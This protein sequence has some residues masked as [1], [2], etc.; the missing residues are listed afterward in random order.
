MQNAGMTTRPFKVETASQAIVAL[1]MLRAGHPDRGSPRQRNVA[2]D[3]V[4]DW[5]ERRENDITDIEKG[6]ARLLLQ[7][8]EIVG[9]AER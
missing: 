7:A 9:R 8:A 5:I 6:A 1:T 2:I 3:A 4:I